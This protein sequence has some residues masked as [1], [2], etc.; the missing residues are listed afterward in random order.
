[1]ISTAWQ[2]STRRTP[3]AVLS[4]DVAGIWSD[5]SLTEARRDELIANP[6][7]DFQA[8]P[9]EVRKF[10]SGWPGP[11]FLLAAAGRGLFQWRPPP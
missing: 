5:D 10:G 9:M 8:W 1:M 4:R 2:P 7:S 6:L 3:R 11:A